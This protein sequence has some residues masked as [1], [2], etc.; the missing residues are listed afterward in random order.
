LKYYLIAGE[1]SGDLHGSNLIKALKKQDK[2]AEFRCFGGDLMEQAGAKLVKHYREMA[3]MGVWEVLLNLRTIKKNMR[4]CKADILKYCPDVL[5]LIYY[6]GFNLRIAKYVKPNEIKVYY[7]ISPKIWFWKQ[8][9][10]KIIKK[11]VDKMFSILPFEVDFYKKHNYEIDYVGNPVLDAIEEKKKDLKDYKTFIAENN[12]ED[13]KILALLP[14]SR[15]QEIQRIF[16]EMLN[17]AIQF[18]D[19]QL[20]IAGTPAI[21]LEM[22]KEYTEG[23]NTKIVM[24]KTYNLLHHAKAAIV[25]SGTATLE[26]ALMNTPQVVCYKTSPFSYKIGKLVINVKKVK[27]F[28]LVNLILD[29]EVVKELLQVNLAQDIYE[30]ADLILHNG[31]HRKTMLENYSLLREKLG[32]VGASEKAGKLIFNY[33]N[34]K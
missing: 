13:Q 10:I 23:L 17:A 29:K 8:S 3:F 11:Y 7:Y 31:E 2:N 25:T 4:V 20:V 33:L 15:K 34:M 9:R 1:A 16:P 5:I 12:L 28:S 22:Y 6:A 21:P 18:T 24:D 19:Y 30:E 14:G 26:T 27:F 32:E